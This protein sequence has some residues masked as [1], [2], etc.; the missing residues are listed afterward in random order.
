MKSLIMEGVNINQLSKDGTSCLHISSDQMTLPLLESGANVF[1]T[2]KNGRLPIHTK[3][4][5]GQLESVRL[6]IANN[7]PINIQDD[8]GLTPL[9]F[10]VASGHDL[11]VSLLIQSGAQVHT[12]LSFPICV[13]CLEVRIPGDDSRRIEGISLLHIAAMLPRLN[14]D[15]FKSLVDAGLDINSRTERGTTPLIFAI[16]WQSDGKEFICSQIHPTFNKRESKEIVFIVQHLLNRGADVNAYNINQ[17]G[18]LHHAA[19]QNFTQIAKAL[20]DHG[21]QVDCTTTEGWTPLHIAAGENATEFA[22]LL[23]EYGAQVDFKTSRGFTPLHKA[24]GTNAIDVAKVL[25]EYGAQTDSKDQLG[26]TPLHIAAQENAVD[27]A[28]VLLEYGA[29]VGATDLD[30]YTPLHIAAQN[31]A[32]DVANV[33]LENGASRRL[34]T[35]FGETP[36]TI[37]KRR[38]SKEVEKRLQAAH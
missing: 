38:N 19:K 24:A 14:V 17:L 7:S 4:Q 2:D 23:L 11:V 28:K 26:W 15:V 33:L 13:R 29:Q 12:R 9:F 34:R 21:A 25:L 3:A 5:N 18:P 37:A 10:A 27:V 6:L 20:L 1:L 30:G 36:L 31:N 32:V 8:S 35:V 22:T 16:F